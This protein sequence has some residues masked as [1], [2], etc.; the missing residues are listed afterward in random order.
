VVSLLAELRDDL[1][2]GRWH[3][4]WS[5]ISAAFLDNMVSQAESPAVQPAGPQ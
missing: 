5:P 3:Q 2:C 1:C 4:S